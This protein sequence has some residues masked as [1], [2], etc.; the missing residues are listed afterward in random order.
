LETGVFDTPA[1]AQ[2]REGKIH[3]SSKNRSN[4]PHRVHWLGKKRLVTGPSE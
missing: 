4:P 3:T 2:P 1:A